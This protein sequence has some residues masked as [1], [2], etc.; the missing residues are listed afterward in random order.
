[1]HGRLPSQ[2]ERGSANPSI[3]ILKKVVSALQLKVVD[4]FLEGHSDEN[5]VAMKEED[6]I[7]IRPVVSPPTF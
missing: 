5:D 1:M 2:L 4:F 7:N 6:R 3:T